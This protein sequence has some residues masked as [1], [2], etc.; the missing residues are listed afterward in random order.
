MAVN[1]SIQSIRASDI[2]Q[3]DIFNLLVTAF[4]MSNQEI[5]QMMY[6]EIL[7]LSQQLLNQNQNYVCS[8]LLNLIYETIQN[9]KINSIQYH[10]VQGWLDILLTK[11][12]PKPSA[13]LNKQTLDS[14]FCKL[15]E[16]ACEQLLTQVSEFLNQQV[17]FGGKDGAQLANHEDISKL[18]L[19]EDLLKLLLYSE[20]NRNLHCLL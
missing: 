7:H 6:S 14:T 16:E 2:V 17:N 3:N 1:K 8:Q 13:Y 11:T 9:K 19:A 15:K 5:Q 20:N 12:T 4:L 10:L 18:L